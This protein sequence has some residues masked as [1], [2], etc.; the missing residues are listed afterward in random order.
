[1]KRELDAGCIIFQEGIDDKHTLV[2]L[3][4]GTGKPSSQRYVVGNG[5]SVFNAL[6]VII[7]YL[8]IIIKFQKWTS[9][10]SIKV[11]KIV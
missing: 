8:V 6:T 10:H 9:L 3:I 4:I 11:H 7:G 1:M 5:N 2:Q